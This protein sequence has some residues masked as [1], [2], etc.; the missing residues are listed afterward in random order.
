MFLVL[1]ALGV[2]V[3]VV[4]VLAYRPALFYPDSGD[5]LGQAADLET[6]DWHPPGYALLLVLL[7]P[8]HDVSAIPVANHVLVVGASVCLYAVLVR[9]GVTRW[10]AAVGCAPLPSTPSRS[11][12]SSTSS[13]RP[14]SRPPWRRGSPSCCGHVARPCCGSPRPADSS[15]TPGSCGRPGSSSSSP[16][17]PT[18]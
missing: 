7:R 11:T 14:C 10:L 13:P 8:L 1:V 2:A 3:R 15:A 5:Y 6:T 16:W 12:S 4:S 9:L 17:W 18:C